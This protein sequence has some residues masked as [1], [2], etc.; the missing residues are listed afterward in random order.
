MIRRCSDLIDQPSSMN[1]AVNQ[2][3]NS[4]WLGLSPRAPKLS[5]EETRPEPKCQCQTRF[6]RTRAVSG[7]SGRTIRLRQIYPAG[8]YFLRADRSLL[9][10]G[11]R[12]LG[13]RLGTSGPRVR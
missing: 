2:S 1:L 12:M 6:T 9:L 10:A 7:L 3:S 11:L 5:V 4:G 8:H 13:K